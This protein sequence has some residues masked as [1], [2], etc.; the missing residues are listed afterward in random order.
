[1]DVLLVIYVLG[2]VNT[3]LGGWAGL[4][5]RNGPEYIGTV[6]IA[7]F[8]FI[9]LPSK[10]LKRFFVRDADTTPDIPDF[11]K[12]HWPPQDTAENTTEKKDEA[13]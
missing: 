12:A 4:Q 8:W 6:A 9:F 7:L 2:V 11:I 3:L 5:P 10:M 1:M 13:S